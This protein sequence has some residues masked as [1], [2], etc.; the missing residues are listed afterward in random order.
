MRLLTMKDGLVVLNKYARPGVTIDDLLE[1]AECEVYGG[2]A[3]YAC[4][5]NDDGTVYAEYEI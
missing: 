4:V 2:Y 1:I 3:D 5:E